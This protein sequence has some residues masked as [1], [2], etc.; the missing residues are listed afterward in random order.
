MLVIIALMVFLRI[1]EFNCRDDLCNNWVAV[2]SDLVKFSFDFLGNLFL[3]LIVIINCRPILTAYVWTL[4]VR[5]GGIMQI[6]EG[7]NK[8]AIA[9]CFGII[10]DL[11]GFGVA[12]IIRT[13][14][15]VGRVFDFATSIPNSCAGH[16]RNFQQAGFDPPETARRKGG[17]LGL[18]AQFSVTFGLAQGM[19][20]SLSAPNSRRD[21]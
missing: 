5:R 9:D 15:V 10:F 16:P 19:S 13:N 6:K 2:F 17:L 20:P 4:P 18:A 1:V 7:S 11:H 14:L 12:G 21:K 3:F 8:V